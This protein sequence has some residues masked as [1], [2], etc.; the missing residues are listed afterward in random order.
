MIDPTILQLLTSIPSPWTKYDIE[1]SSTWESQIELLVGAGLVERRETP[2]FS[3][4][5]K[6]EKVQTTIEYT[7]DNGPLLALKNVDVF[8]ME[9]WGSLPREFVRVGDIQ[10]RSSD[11]WDIA[12]LDIAN[13][14]IKTVLEFIYRTGFFIHRPD[15][16][17]RG[18]SFG[19]RWIVE[20]SA[21]LPEVALPIKKSRKQPDHEVTI[22]YRENGH[23]YDDK[24]EA[25]KAYAEL[26]GGNE[27]TLYS[28]LHNQ[29]NRLKQTKTA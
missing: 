15:V 18:R 10:L 7:G 25:V 1:Q 28:Q 14:N 27:A 23:K 13:C 22:W 16:D 20:S 4:P 2:V 8:I 6:A 26:Y 21:P 17:S 5:N 11:Q 29:R 9:R 19:T 12:K 24:K 3:T